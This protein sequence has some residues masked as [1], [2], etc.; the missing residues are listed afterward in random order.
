MRSSWC[1]SVVGDVH[2]DGDLVDMTRSA[3]N[4]AVCGFRGVGDL[5]GH[6]AFSRDHEAGSRIAWQ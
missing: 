2:P 4:T 6:E 5:V 1:R 3:A